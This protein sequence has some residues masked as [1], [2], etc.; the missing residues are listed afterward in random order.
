VEGER[1]QRREGRLGLPALP[2][3]APFV[4][5]P[6]VRLDQVQE[7]PEAERTEFALGQVMRR[8]VAHGRVTSRVEHLGKRPPIPKVWPPIARFL[9]GILRSV[10]G[11]P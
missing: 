7:L 4:E 3:A 5:R 10:G 8:M 1:L 9:P 2:L 11:R 6:D